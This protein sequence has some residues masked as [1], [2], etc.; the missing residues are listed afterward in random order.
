MKDLPCHC[1]KSDGIR[2]SSGVAENRK[3]SVQ[4][5]LLKPSGNTGERGQGSVL[6]CQVAPI[7][8]GL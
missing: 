1:K 3:N 2:Q 7:P 4:G 6:L 5:R 8:A